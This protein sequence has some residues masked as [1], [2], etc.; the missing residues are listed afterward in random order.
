MPAINPLP[1]PPSR[2]DPANFSDRADAFL[3]ALPAYTSEANALLNDV[4][5]SRDTVQGLRDEV[6]AAGLASAATNAATATTKAAEA[7][8]SAAEAFGYLQ[9][10]RATSYGA[11]ANDPVVDPNGNPPTVGD[12]YFNTTMNLLKRFNGVTW[13]ASDIATA[14]LAAPGGTALIGYDDGTAQDVLDNAKPMANYTALRAYTGRAT[15]VRITQTGLA[16]FFRCDDADTTSADNG[17]TIIVDAGGRRWKRLFDGAINGLWFGMIADYTGAPQYDGLDATRITATDNAAAL[18]A[19]VLAA[20]SN[21]NALHIP[22]G[23]YG[24][25]TRAADITNTGDLTIYGDGIA[26]TILDFIYEDETGTSSITDDQA[27]WLLRIVGGNVVEFSRIQIKATTNKRVVGGAVTNADAVYYSKVF[28]VLVKNAAEVRLIDTYS[29][30]F[31]GKG[32]GVNGATKFR[33]ANIKG[34]YCTWS[35]YWIDG[36]GSATVFGGEVSYNGYPGTPTTGYGITFSTNC[37]IVYVRGVYAHHNYRKGIDTHGTHRYYVTECQFEDNL[38]YHCAAA[39][40]VPP[41]GLVNGVLSVTNNK[42]SNGMTTESENW[43]RAAYQAA[44]ANGFTDL[45]H[46]VCFLNDVTS[47]MELLEFAGNTVEAAY[48]GYDV[49]TSVTESL[50]QLFSRPGKIVFSDNTMPLKKYGS[51]TAV[52]GYAFTPVALTAKRVVVDHN[53]LTYT[54]SAAFTGT[55]GADFG[56]AYSLGATNSATFPTYGAIDVEFTRNTTVLNDAKLLTYATQGRTFPLRFE[57]D[58]KFR[59]HDN[60]TVSS[61]RKQVFADG[62]WF[63]DVTYLDQ[64]KASL[65]NNSYVVSGITH[66]WDWPRGRI[67][68]RYA[69]SGS[70]YNR[71]PGTAVARII[72]D[73]SAVLASI[74]MRVFAAEKPNPVNVWLG[75]PATTNTITGT[76]ANFTYAV[77]AAYVDTDGLTKTAITVTTTKTITIL[78][79]DAALTSTVE[80]Y[81]IERVDIL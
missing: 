32:F 66:V 77:N 28:G 29:T 50:V 48:C 47:Q 49:M 23:H 6:M 33:A 8:A 36:A 78:Y 74:D 70:G 27:N 17:G 52:S 65:K 12:E 46:R 34:D 1:T 53:H 2:N 41:A 56:G 7:S 24:V 26:E 62:G 51:T 61:V 38:V 31:N 22:G 71:S 19:A 68:R 58:Y 14:N 42:F 10:Y 21:H 44:F 30:R 67:N 69:R 63:S 9:T 5:T 57:N 13:Q 43:L 75:S 39:N 40:T 4:H 81:G 60:I 20:V 15:G 37:G 35:P 72:V 79:V 76:D 3:A 18:R 16:G 64:T 80:S 55:N 45:A 54:A 73:S 25:K 11:L 59:M